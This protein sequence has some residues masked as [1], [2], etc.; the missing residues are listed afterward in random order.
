MHTDRPLAE[1]SIPDAGT[2]THQERH[3]SLRNAPRNGPSGAAPVHTIH[4]LYP[5]AAQH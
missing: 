2:N 4:M 1:L 3:S 5:S